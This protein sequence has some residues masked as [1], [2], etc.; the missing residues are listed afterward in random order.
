MRLL[1]DD[2]RQYGGADAAVAIA[3]EIWWARPLA[4]IA[5]IPVVMTALRALYHWIAA[6]R[7]CAAERCER[8]LS[9]AP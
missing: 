5:R 8:S 2:G 3:K 1:L 7:H 9:K 6:R 4:W